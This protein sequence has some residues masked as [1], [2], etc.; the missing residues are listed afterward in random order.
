ME[1]FYSH[2]KL[3]GGLVLGSGLVTLG[4]CILGLLVIHWLQADMMPL[5]HPEWATFAA[6]LIIIGCNTFF[7]S[8]FISTMSMENPGDN[9]LVTFS[10]DRAY[11]KESPGIDTLAETPIATS[12]L[13]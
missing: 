10:A 2:F 11:G 8:L 9:K 3:E 13:E 4:V 12:S 1:W 6:T 7:S 5:P